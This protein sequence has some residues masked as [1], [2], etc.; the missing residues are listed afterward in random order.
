MFPGIANQ[1]NAIPIP[2]GREVW[3]G[4]HQSARISHWKSLGTNALTLNIDSKLNR[5][6]WLIDFP[7]SGEFLRI[8][9]SQKW[10]KIIFLSKKIKNY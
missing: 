3:H 8:L 5:E 6:T 10:S 9:P 1:E 4:I 7:T 2:E